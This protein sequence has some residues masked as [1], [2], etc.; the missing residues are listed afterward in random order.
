MEDTWLLQDNSV[1]LRS[2]TVWMQQTWGFIPCFHGQV[3]IFASRSCCW[4]INFNLK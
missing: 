4:W 1:A 2:C 3:P